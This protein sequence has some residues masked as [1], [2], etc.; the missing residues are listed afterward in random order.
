MSGFQREKQNLQ[1]KS[2]QLGKKQG[3]KQ[4]KVT[5]SA[6]EPNLSV[7]EGKSGFQ[8]GKSWVLSRKCQN[9]R[10]KEKYKCQKKE[11]QVFSFE[12]IWITWKKTGIWKKSEFQQEYQNLNFKAEKSDFQLGKKCGFQLGKSQNFNEKNK[13]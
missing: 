4:E 3:F 9:F 10:E 13:I 5:I 2:Q 8:L 6:R 7:K 1:R 12:R 11:S